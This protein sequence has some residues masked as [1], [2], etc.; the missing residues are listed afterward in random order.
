MRH[1]IS[2]YRYVVLADGHFGPLSSKT[3]NSAVRYLPD[4]IVAVVDARNAGRTV[5]D[6][7]GFGGSIPVVE[8]LEAGLAH[9]PT[10]ALVGIAPQGGRL[11]EPWRALLHRAM[12][13]GLPVVSGLHV[14]L[15]DD[16]DLIE[17]ARRHGVSIHDLRKPP[18]DL[19]VSTGVARNVE[20]LTVLTVG[21]DCNI[22][23]MTAAL[24]V[25]DTL[26][27]RGTRVGFAATGQTGILIEG[28]GIAVDA[29]VA[30][31]IGGAAERLVLE[32]AR[33]NDVVLVEGQGSLVHPGYSG[34]TLG[35]LHGSMPDAMLLCHQ[36]SRQCPFAESR[37]YDWM[38]LPTVPEMIRICEGAMAPLRP[39]RVI[40]IALN[41]WDLTDD[42]S[43]EAAER[44]AR[45]TGLPTVDPV[46]FDA[47]PLADA[48][49][50]AE[51]E[52]RSA[53]R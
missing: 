53:R 45:A 17:A 8:S 31:F 19:P 4:R 35:L 20:P 16:P 52:K 32:A 10:A 42:E 7:L 2:Q 34:V 43:R 33:G 26:R 50:A 49:L 44:I 27:T 6:V 51:E 23:K 41:T 15:G 25:R 12:A 46:R 38:R 39:S 40:G 13:A 9:G 48:I 18:A 47:G 36:P 24:Q 5:H 3:A 21:T 30:D 37:A 22:G 29:V 14:H 28:W 11:P 1:D